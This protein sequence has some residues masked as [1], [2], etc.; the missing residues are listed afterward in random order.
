MKLFK[1]LLVAPATL[2][3][4]APVA[5]TANEFNLTDV[6]DYTSTT[7]VE[8]ITD[9]DA[10]KELAV[11]NSRVDG[12]EARFNDFEAGSFSETTTASFSVD[13]ATGYEDGTDAKDS[14]GAYYGFQIDL[15]TSFTGEDSLDISLDGGNSGGQVTELDLNS[16]TSEALTVDGVSYTFPVMG[17]TV[18][19]GDNM[20]GSTLFSTACVYG[21]PGNNLDDCG[22]GSSAIGSGEGTALGA[23]YEF[24]NGLSVAVGYTGAGSSSSGLATKES[25]DSV[26]AQVTYTADTYGVSLT[27]ANVEASGNDG[28]NY[29]AL[30]GYWSPSDA[31]A[32]PSISLGYEKGTAQKTTDTRQWFAGL[33]WDE[34][35]PGTFGVAVGTIGAS[36]DGPDTTDPHHN[37]PELIMYEAYYSYPIND[38]MTVT[39][40]IYTK[41]TAVG[42]DDLTGVMVKTSFSF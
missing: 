40:L 8:S 14:V 42:S 3:L 16:T 9:F 4:L 22:N 1:S 13:F 11:T 25:N 17:A 24:D 36:T 10:A 31:G 2:G 29:V 37:D 39:P 27:G 32:I 19:V 26:A 23:S 7:E 12:L 6:S 28:R 18:F 41:E 15:N 30:N 20:D 38:G 35:G 5:V 33:Q 34:A 21:G